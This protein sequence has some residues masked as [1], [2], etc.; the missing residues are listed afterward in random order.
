MAELFNNDL[1]LLTAMLAPRMRSIF[2]D[3]VSV[4]M[5]FI[6]PELVKKLG[7]IESVMPKA[8][9]PEGF[10]DI[11]TLKGI[12]AND[13]DLMV[14]AYDRAYNPDTEKLVYESVRRSVFTVYINSL[15]TGG[16]MHLM[17]T[18]KSNEL[19]FP[20]YGLINNEYSRVVNLAD[21]NASSAAIDL[22]MSF[23]SSF[24]FINSLT[25]GG[26]GYY[27]DQLIVVSAPPGCFT[28]DTK[29][30][31]LD[32]KYRTM[33]DLYESGA[34]NFGV[35]CCDENGVPHV[36]RAERCQLTKHVNSIYEIDVDG[37][38]VRCT[39]DH[40]FML[41]SG[42]WIEAKD[43]VKND[44]LMPIHRVQQPHM[45]AMLGRK[46]PEPVYEALYITEDKGPFN[47]YTHR[48]C[49]E[50]LDPENRFSIVHHDRY[51][52]EKDSFDSLNNEF[53]NLKLYHSSSEH[54]KRH[55]ELSA[56]CRNQIIDAGRGT[57]LTS[58][59]VTDRN[60]FNWKYRYEE[61]YNSVK[62]NF[63]ASIPQTI[64]RNS[65]DKSEQKKC[66]VR[67]FLHGLIDS[68]RIESPT[69][70]TKELYQSERQKFE[71]S[72]FRTPS[73]EKAMYYYDGNTEQMYKEAACWQNHTVREVRCIQLDEP[74]AVY[75]LVNVEKYHNFAIMTDERS[76]SGIFVHNC[77]KSLFCISEAA[78]ACKQGMKVLYTALGDLTDF[79]FMSRPC[80]I[81]LNK[82]MM[83][84]V[85]NLAENCND[86][87]SRFPYM[88]NFDVDFESPG[89]I[90]V[91]DWIEK[92][93]H[94]NLLDT[95]DVFVVDYDTNFKSDKD[96]M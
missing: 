59:R 37:E 18:I 54:R 75:D 10:R 30:M 65:G 31:T 24:G 71:Y 64:K 17:E 2:K 66:G 62:D 40:K 39:P 21:L 43:L 14:A 76:N 67:K 83:S 82:P 57:R 94:S 52:A 38:K 84:V 45:L 79:D 50:Y 61:T 22:G 9:T 1:Q 35:Y 49:K 78:S 56:K 29:V 95:H 53:E 93:K 77:G 6:N 8:T 72:N 7:E 55:C 33:K 42:E 15:K 32:G 44:S 41:S 20:E 36:S 28:G 3:N 4:L 80:S 63:K 19:F 58:Q 34:E 88:T 89:T 68:H 27:Q 13:I 74:V 25:I 26:K 69:Q 12:D 81:V 85:D 23:K 47:Y 5:R 48:L 70:I 92:L 16:V 51:D 60:C 73:F 91:T 90:S 46:E 87:F 86:M 96:S 11:L